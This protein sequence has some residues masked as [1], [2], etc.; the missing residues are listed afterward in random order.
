MNPTP[1]TYVLK[2][3]SS[4]VEIKIHC[5]PTGYNSYQLNTYAMIPGSVYL[6]SADQSPSS[7]SQDCIVP[8][9]PRS[10]VPS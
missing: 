6:L 1:H 10:I 5:K 4:N 9:M 7:P 2:T 3:G 8:S